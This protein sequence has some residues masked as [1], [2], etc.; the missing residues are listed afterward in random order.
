[1][2]DICHRSERKS[3]W[4]KKPQA[5]HENHKIAFSRKRNRAA[6]APPPLNLYPLSRFTLKCS[7]LTAR[8]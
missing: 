4:A 2:D 7:P 1:M 8:R 5:T 3:R 6:S